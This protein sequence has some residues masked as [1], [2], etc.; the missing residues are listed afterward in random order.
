MS[1]PHEVF[2]AFQITAPNA[3]GLAMPVDTYLGPNK[4][5]R[6]LRAD[7]T[8]GECGHIAASLGYAPEYLWTCL[9]R[10]GVLLE[11][12]SPA[13]MAFVPKETP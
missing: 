5:I 3:D 8:C 2:V 10:D 12:S 9:L 6:Y 1:A 11:M 4:N 7:L 13:C